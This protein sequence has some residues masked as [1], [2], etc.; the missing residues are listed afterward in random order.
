MT[1][2]RM[3]IDGIPKEDLFTRMRAMRDH[4]AGWREGKTF[5]LVYNVTEDVYEVLK[6][7]F[8]MFFSE[9]GLDPTAFP[10]LRT[11]E[12]EVVRMTASLLNGDEKVVGNMTSG[13][14]ES[15]LLAVK[16]ARDWGLAHKGIERPEMIL[17]LTAHPAFDKAAQY[18]NVNAVHTP[19]DPDFRADA[20]AVRAAMNE[21]TV[22]IVGS[23]PSY[24]HGIIDPIEELAEIAQEHGI[25]FHTDACI[26]GFM[27][28]FVERLG[29]PVPLW[30]FRVPGVT[31]ISADVHKYGYAAKP[32]SVLLFR[33]REVRRHQLFVYTD[34]PGGIYA[35][36][37]MTGTRPGGAIAAAWAIMNYLGES[38]YLAINKEV[39]RT[40]MALRAGVQ[41]LDGLKVIGEPIMSIFAIASDRYNIF[42]IGDEMTVRGWRLDRQQFPPSLH[43]SVNYVHKDTIDVFLKDLAES[44]FVAKKPSIRKTMDALILKAAEIAT[45]ILPESLVSKLTTHASGFVG[46]SG[47]SIPQRSAAMY[48]MMASLPNRGDLRELV[49]DLVEGFTQA[50]D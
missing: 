17:P 11:F 24:P 48:G 26:G 36:A 16:T 40:T 23:A 15:I 12:T 49:L 22:L 2:F 47:S 50:T 29:Y 43:V 32:A 14:T 3:P 44:I 39:M 13:G 31:S 41:A 7:A 9:N 8:M 5:S 37:P 18:F 27:L 35:S 4:D 46:V 10:S 34:W 33:H 38:G 6:E 42:E 45:R 19:I 20:E 30:D 21:N 28:P 25:L 1:Q